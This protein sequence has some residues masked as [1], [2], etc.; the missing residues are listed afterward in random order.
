VL[1][2]VA[3]GLAAT[4]A[5]WTGPQLYGHSAL[6]DYVR[7][8]SFDHL[9]RAG[10]LYPRWCPDTYFGHG[11]PL[12]HF[13]APLPYAITEGFVLLGLPV[14][15]AIKATLVG[16]LLL[17]GLGMYLFCRDVAGR[18]A[19][20][21]AG[22]AYMLAPYHLVD[23]VVRHALGEHVAFAF[24]PVACWGVSGMVRGRATVR[25]V[26]G[27]LAMAA[28]VLSH[29]VTA[30]L[31]LGAVGLWWLVLAWRTRRAGAVLRGAAVPALGLLLSLFF[32]LPA[33]V[34]KEGTWAEES[35][36]REFFTYSDHF[37]HP[38]QLFVPFWGFGGS[39]KG[40]AEDYMSFQVGIPH[41]L[42][43][44]AA[45]V[46][47][48]GRRRLSRGGEGGAPSGLR[49]LFRYGLLLFAFA[50]AFTLPLSDPVYQALPLL[51][52]VQFPW[53]F[54][55]FA[56]FASSLLAVAVETLARGHLAPRRVPVVLGVAA[57]VVAG[58][59]G[60]YLAPRFAYQRTDANDWQSDTAAR[61]RA[62]FARGEP[63][64]HVWELGDGDVRRWVRESG[65][66]MTSRDDYLPRTVKRKPRVL[67][68]EPARWFGNPG[69]ARLRV[70][71]PNPVDVAVGVESSVDGALEILRFAF[72][73]WQATVDGREVPIRTRAPYGTILVSVPAGTHEVR[74]HFGSTTLRTASA[75]A[76]AGALAVL[77]AALALAGVR[78]R[79]REG[80][81]PGGALG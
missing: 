74:V 35:L 12:F 7:M 14:H 78:R 27:A 23:M 73:G 69:A 66:T 1:A 21:L 31:G 53:R 40:V 45:L 44:L 71:E 62:R 49:D 42:F 63:V 13:Y 39:R 16:T 3:T 38:S 15:A 22:L 43:V 33:L 70:T 59:Y 51:R 76:S 20:A 65:E 8:A 36:T 58:A 6:M 28:L 26:V 77:L 55:V 48:A 29:N 52:Y 10:I 4:A 25:I 30:M 81:A 54:L 41:W 18:W 17:S 5:F 2:L 37:V 67:P 34:E 72:P 75:W 46:V 19:S 56:A 50:V 32:W 9:V 68:E 11:S 47:L 60:A 80:A 79:G 24:L 64:R 61:V 57:L